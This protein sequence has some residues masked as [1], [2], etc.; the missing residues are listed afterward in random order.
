[1][2]ATRWDLITAGVPSPAGRAAAAGLHD[3]EATGAAFPTLAGGIVAVLLLLLPLVRMGMTLEIDFGEGWN[4]YVAEGVLHGEPVYR[5]FASLVPNNYPPLSFYALA[6]LHHLTGWALLPLGRGVAL[7]SLL[8]VAVQVGLAAR[9][10]GAARQDAWLAG[11]LFVGLVAAGA[12]RYVAMNDPQLLAHAIAAAALLAYLRWPTRRVPATVPLMAILVTAALFTKHNLVALPIAL[13]IAIALD[14]PERLVPWCLTAG[15]LIAGAVAALERAS[16]GLFVASLLMGRRY[17]LDTLTGVAGIGLLTMAVPTIVTATGISRRSVDPRLRVVLV[18]F[19]VATATG[20]GFSGGSGADVN[21][22]FDAFVAIAVACAV[23]LTRLRAR[24]GAYLAASLAVVAWLALALPIRLL[25]P[26]RYQQ[27]LRR[28]QATIEDVRYLRAHRG[29]AYC[30][31]MLLCYLAGK[32]LVL[33]PYFAPEL[34]AI[35]DVPEEIV[36]QPF[37]Q[38]TFGIVQLDR[39]ILGPEAE[40]GGAPHARLPGG[41]LSTIRRQYRLARVSSN[42]AFYVPAS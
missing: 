21:M 26:A 23:V 4:A 27:L 2:R 25:T 16:G 20:I 9:L 17:G 15:G 42:G 31:R 22:F 11:L 6:A 1:M 14:A 34:A 29:N 24:P 36:R 18:Y 13:T 12:A 8:L 37:D 35:G 3:D 10:C 5:P 32:P 41:V 38:R 39:P 19:G 33:Q 30:E 40:I 7:V 28:E